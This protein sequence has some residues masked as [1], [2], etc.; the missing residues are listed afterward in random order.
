MQL[1]V[2]IAEGKIA[3]VKPERDYKSPLE[4]AVQSLTKGPRRSWPSRA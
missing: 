3:K 1:M 2:E 4:E